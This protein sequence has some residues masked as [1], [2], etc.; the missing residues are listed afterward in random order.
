MAMITW[1]QNRLIRQ[2]DREILWIEAWGK[3]ALRIRATKNATMDEEAWALLEP[4]QEKAELLVDG[5]CVA[6]AGAH[7]EVVAGASSVAIRNGSITALLSADGRLVF[8]NQDGK[9]LLEEYL[10]TEEALG[11]SRSLLKIEAREIK[12]GRG[13]DCALTMRFESNPKERLYGMGQYQQ[14]V[15]NLKGSILELAQR[16]SQ[17]SVPF[18]CSDQGY[19]FLW[20]NPAI[21]R[22][23]FGTNRTEWHAQS[24]KQLDYWITAGDTPGEILEQYLQV[25]GLPPMMPEYALGF[26]QSKLRYQTQEELLCVAREYH[27][28][29]IP[30]SVLVIDYFHWPNQGT[31]RFDKTYW[32]DPQAMVQELKELGIEL[33]VSVW[34]TVDADCENYS[35]MLEQGL[36]VAADR[37]L[38]TQMNFLG[39]ETFYDATNPR[40]REYVWNKVKE[41]YYDLGIR[42]FWLDVAEPEYSVYDFELYRYQKGSNLQVGNIY[43]LMYAKGFYDGMRQAGDNQPL[44][45]VRCAWAGSQRFGTL[46]WSGDIHSSFRSLRSQVA[47]GLNMAMAGIPWWTTDIGGFNDGATEDPH[48]RELLIRW[49]QYGT[50]CPV[51]RLHGYRLPYQEPMS[52]EVGGGMCDTGAPN[53]VWSFGKQA[54]EILVRYIQ[55]RERLRPYIR[56]Q[57]KLAHEQGIPPMRPLFYDF[58]SEEHAWQTE[59]AYLFGAHLLIAP[60]LHEKAVQRM[61]YL[62][63][64]KSWIEVETGRVY[65]GG[66]WVLADAPIEAIPVFTDQKELVECFRG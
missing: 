63:G 50:F 3:N 30:L 22:V 52:K 56:E 18:V 57:M 15:L 47:A 37:G 51:M 23:S 16:N 43:P 65:E 7:D 46:V 54:Y 20:N 58:P 32:P 62:P 60:I 10:R 27:R 2:F 19:G 59:D 42:T 34:P 24:T 66:Q 25:T 53:E 28:R 39:N 45:L 21:G 48:F 64:D 41:H 33:M 14:E 31:W 11:E 1:Q 38:R 8:Q 55:I 36:L 5:R 61:V 26:W 35:E 12:M 17:A 13:E 29:R 49:F 40:A 44:N 6:G 9:V 4:G